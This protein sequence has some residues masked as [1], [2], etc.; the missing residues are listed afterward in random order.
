MQHRC[1]IAGDAL[2]PLVR[3]SALVVGVSLERLGVAR[4]LS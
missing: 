3:L 4:S 1:N 2:R